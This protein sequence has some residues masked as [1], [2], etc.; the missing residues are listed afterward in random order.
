MKKLSFLIVI[1]LF[2]LSCTNYFSEEYYDECFDCLS[3]YSESGREL[4][5]SISNN[6]K[7]WDGKLFY[8]TDRKHWKEWFGETIKGKCIYLRGINNTYMNKVSCQYVFPHGR[9]DYIESI[10]GNIEV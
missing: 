1:S 5:L 3:F 4:F 2:V 10:P 6:K 7:N 9:Y 8:S